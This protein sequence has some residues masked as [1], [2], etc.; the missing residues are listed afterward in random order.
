MSDCSVARFRTILLGAFAALAI[1]LASVGVFGVL[2]YF[3][4]QHTREIGI[5]I[6]LGARPETSC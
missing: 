1:A 3:V 6:A 4:A 5:R 2:S